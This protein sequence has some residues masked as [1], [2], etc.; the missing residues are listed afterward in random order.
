M[1]PHSID[2]SNQDGIEIFRVSGYVDA[3]GGKEIQDAG[4]D[5]LKKG[6]RRFVLD[7][8]ACPLVNSSGMV[9]IVNLAV[10]TVFEFNG[11]MV[12][13][14]LDERKSSLFEMM[15]IFRAAV[16]SETLETGIAKAKSAKR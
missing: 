2:I 1:T 3:K 5:L 14:G 8:S 7:F 16:S 9:A 6:S 10:K 12:I 4:F 15:G 11:F 13:S